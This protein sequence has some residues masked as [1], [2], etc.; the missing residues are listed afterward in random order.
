[1]GVLGK[2]NGRLNVLLP[3]YLSAV[4]F[5]YAHI[6]L[7]LFWM[8]LQR[9]YSYSAQVPVQNS[10]ESPVPLCSLSTKKAAL[11]PVT[12]IW[13]P[14]LCVEPGDNKRKCQWSTGTGFPFPFICPEPFLTALGL[15]KQLIVDLECLSPFMF[16][17]L[18]WL[19]LFCI[20]SKE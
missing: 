7:F 6:R 4:M 15:L 8:K 11:S 20:C 9:E 2:L 14:F 3:L 18:Q 12:D 10:S 17:S 5:S 1:M 16:A 19:W 13:Q